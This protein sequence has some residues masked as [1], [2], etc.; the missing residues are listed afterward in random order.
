MQRFKLLLR[1]ADF[2]NYLERFRFQLSKFSSSKDNALKEQQKTVLRT[3]TDLKLHL[4]KLCS[5]L[6]YNLSMNFDFSYMFE[7]GKQWKRIPNIFN[8]SNEIVARV[9]SSSKMKYVQQR[10]EVE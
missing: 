4:M 10:T 9:R 7:R 2:K 8:L 3:V 1:D 5:D 6:H